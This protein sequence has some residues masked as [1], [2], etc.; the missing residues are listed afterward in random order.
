[1]GWMIVLLIVYL[2]L[3]PRPIAIP[4]TEGD[5]FGHALAY[6]VL[7]LWFA[8]L[9]LDLRQRYV[10]AVLCVALGVGLEFAQLLTETREFSIADMACGRGRRSAGMARSAASRT[11]VPQATGR[12]WRR[13]AGP[14]MP[15]TRQ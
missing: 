5:K 8:Q 11:R 13:L 3:T 14:R 15:A 6:G 1:M 9:Y 10:L 2:S 12:C 4:V 7:M